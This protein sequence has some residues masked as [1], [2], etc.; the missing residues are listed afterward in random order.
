MM[1]VE[2]YTKRE[3]SEFR[4]VCYYNSVGQIHRTDGPAIIFVNGDKYWMVNEKRHRLNGPAVIW[5]TD[6]SS[7]MPVQEWWINNKEYKKSK[8]NRLALFYMLEHKRMG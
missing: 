4:T 8:H 7:S 3:V 2:N 1:V 6:T 5:Y